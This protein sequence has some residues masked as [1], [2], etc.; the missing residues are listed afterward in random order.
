MHKEAFKMPF[1]HGALSVLFSA[2]VFLGAFLLFSVQPM[3]AKEMLPQL[4]GSPSVWN[5]CMLTFQ[6]LLLAGY[7]YAV[8][9]QKSRKPMAALQIL[10]LCGALFVLPSAGTSFALS[11]EHPS[12]DLI[13]ALIR[14]IGLPFFVLAGMSTLLQVWFAQTGAKD[15]YRLYSF[16]NAGSL[17]ALALFP[18][19]IEPNVPPETQ[20]MLWSAG[21]AAYGVLVCLCL[22][23]G[24]RL[25]S[26]ENVSNGGAEKVSFSKAAFWTAASF[27]PCS[28]ML[29]VTT[30]ITTDLSP[31]P[32]LWNV[33]LAL[34][35]LAFVLAFSK[36]GKSV[37][38]LFLLL[39]PAAVIA[40]ITMYVL[41]FLSHRMALPHLAVSFV[42]M[43][44][45]LGVLAQSRPKSGN[46]SVFYFCVALGGALGGVFNG[47]A[48]PLIF[49]TYAEYGL[50][51]LAALSFAPA[52]T[53]EKR[54]AQD[55][56]RDFAIP[57]GIF[58]LSFGLLAFAHMSGAFNERIA[59]I[60]VILMIGSLM[61]ATARDPLRCALTGGVLI[62]FGSYVYSGQNP[63]SVFHAKILQERNFFGVTS[64]RKE[65]SAKGLRTLL[66]HGTTLHGVQ[67]AGAG[68]K[69]EPRLYYAPS[70]G[71]GNA[72]LTAAKRGDKNIAVVGMGAATLSAYARKD[73]KW[74]YYEIDP[75]I[76]S[77]SAGRRPVFS[78]FKDHT[79]DAEIKIGDG[80]VL[81]AKENKKFDVIVLDAFSS[82]A[83]P[84]H[85]L[86]KEALET[87]VSR[88]S[89]KGMILFHA[90]NRILD[91]PSVLSAGA[92]AL[93]L[94]GLQFVSKNPEDGSSVVWTALTP[95]K[96]TA[97]LLRSSSPLWRSLPKVSG[98]LLW[99]DAYADIPAAMKKNRRLPARNR[100]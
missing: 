65:Q 27:V 57:L 78:Y 30:Y 17:A 15:P 95:S 29:G 100:R 79:P 88:L 22:F 45:C 40:F 53:G 18:I 20:R 87:Y 71:V 50:M 69:D 11:P 23:A 73:Q 2:T 35:L 43:Q 44:V 6:T 48:A 25:K 49:N 37:L 64:V 56:W 83:V 85:L 8:F 21:F 89:P 34:Y 70:S 76:V 77:L 38:N 93:N 55:I 84:S 42:M 61:S 9:V 90:S 62:L 52:Q 26:G 46:L 5:V 81:L 47:L 36:W 4:G 99:T 63:Y 51:F 1:R 92:S 86:T 82:D 75:L 19:F 60:V 91:L 68:A 59:G 13:A 58:F 32:L 3:A 67:Y 94:T 12:F 41:S 10:L 98:D 80:R 39:R 97:A 96:E 28:L 7:A 31:S 74:T 33:P 16:S 66:F 24:G 54:S 14:R 72:L